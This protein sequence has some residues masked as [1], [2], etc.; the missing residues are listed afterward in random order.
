MEEYA[1]G[2]EEN[3]R[4]CHRDCKVNCQTMVQV[5]K[6]VLQGKSQPLPS[7]WSKTFSTPYDCEKAQ[8]RLLQMPIAV[9]KINGCCVV[10]EKRKDG[11]CDTFFKEMPCSSTFSQHVSQCVKMVTWVP[12]VKNLPLFQ[13]LVQF[14]LK[15]KEKHVLAS[16]HNMSAR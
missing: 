6:I 4:E 3:C 11:C 16:S 8:R 7:S 2:K 14:M 5:A 9:L 12:L 15:G 13:V 10:V 1:F